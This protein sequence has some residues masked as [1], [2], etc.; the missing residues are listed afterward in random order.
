MPMTLIQTLLALQSVDQ[1]WDEKASL[2]QAVRG[3]LGDESAIEQERQTQQAL[4]EKF[5]QVRAHL[6]DAEM[7]L[8]SVEAKSEQV[9]KDLY[10]GDIISPRELENLR[11]DSEYLQRRLESLEETALTAMGELEE[12]QEAVTQGQEELEQFETEWAETRQE[13]IET[14]KVLRARLQALQGKRE[15]LREHVDQ[16]ALARYDELRKRKH[17]VVMAAEIGGTCQVCH[18]TIPSNKVRL[19]EAGET[20]TTCDGCGRILYAG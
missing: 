13:D 3:R 20:L 15:E 12:L 18:V 17:G 7:E 2:F 4:E 5:S 6:R 16:R 11:Q 8:E 10:S 9:Q 14:Y 19:V 1:E